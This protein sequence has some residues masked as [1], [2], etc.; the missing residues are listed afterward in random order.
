MRKRKPLAWAHAEYIKLLRSASDGKVF[1]SIPEVANRYLGDN[2][3]IKFL[4]IWKFNYQINTIKSGYT[5]RIQAD[6]S[7]RLHWSISD[8]QTVNDNDSTTTAIGIN[9]VDISID[10]YQK[11]TINFTF[12]WIE[13][14]HWENRNYQVNITV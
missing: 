1:D 10:S 9:F 3:S 14:N 8:W 2:K 5:L 4:E 12:F 6:T 13:A 11:D 7:F